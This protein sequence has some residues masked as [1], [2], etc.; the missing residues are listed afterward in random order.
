MYVERDCLQWTGRTRV[1]WSLL[2]H[3]TATAV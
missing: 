3:H 2:L 1:G